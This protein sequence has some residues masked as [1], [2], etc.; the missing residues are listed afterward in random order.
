[1]NVNNG[2]SESLLD[3]LSQIVHR[4]RKILIMVHDNPDPDGLASA[5]ALKY[6]L[7]AGWKVGSLITYGGY[8]GRAE[9]VAMIRQLR[10]EIRHVS[11]INL[12][13]FSVVALVDTQ[14]GTGNNAL[15]R[16]IDP[17]I[18]IDHHV[19]IY[20]RTLKAKFHDI[21]T[22]YGSTSSILTEYLKDAGI[23]N[24]DR[25]VATALF[26]GI[27]SDTSD[28]GRETTPRDLAA[29]LFLY[30]HV[31]FRILSRIEHPKVSIEYVQT[32]EK[33]LNSAVM[34]RDVIISDMGPIDNPES[35]AEMADFLNRIEGVKWVLCLG[36][37]QESIYFSLRTTRRQGNAGLAARK[38]VQDIGYGGG[39]NMTAGG[40]VGSN[41]EVA[42][43]YKMLAD[44]L[45]SRFLKEINRRD[46]KGEK[47]GSG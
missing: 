33:A 29:H 7:H 45:I 38:M 16:S 46:F 44:I 31:L 15:P 13:D 42:D 19:P 41:A 40:K 26:Y 2:N 43:R 24:L 5:Y 27:R 30:P 23:E 11:E 20:S 12:R 4:K 28:L 17:E 6:L 34:D 14:P 3:K 39:H 37:F 25:K 35:L 22:D 10:I 9:N 32:F 8:I 1:M 36:G 21:R 18:V 47:L